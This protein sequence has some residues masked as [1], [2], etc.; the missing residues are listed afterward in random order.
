MS[1]LPEG[2][3]NGLDLEKA[4]DGTYIANRDKDQ[5]IAVCRRTIRLLRSNLR[6]AEDM[7]RKLRE[8]LFASEVRRKALE[9]ENAQLQAELAELRM[10]KELLSQELKVIQEE[11]KF[12]LETAHHLFQY[13]AEEVRRGGDIH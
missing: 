2:Y 3:R 8:A 9:E 13:S 11:Y 5:L 6:G 4:I 1:T 12:V 7:L 10:G